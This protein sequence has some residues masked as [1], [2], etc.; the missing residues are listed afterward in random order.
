MAFC[1]QG[2]VI[3]N[4]TELHR[5][6]QNFVNAQRLLPP[7]EYRRPYQLYIGAIDKMVEEGAMLEK[8][9]LPFVPVDQ[10]GTQGAQA[11]VSAE[12]LTAA[13]SGQSTATYLMEEAIRLLPEPTPAPTIAPIAGRVLQVRP[14]LIP[15]LYEIVMHV[16][17]ESWVDAAE[18]RVG[19]FSASPYRIITIRHTCAS[20]FFDHIAVITTD[21]R[22]FESPKYTI[23]RGDA[24]P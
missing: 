20:D 5:I 15:D 17:I 16:N 1:L 11:P 14:S 7:P 2:D 3:D 22:Y 23:E 4:C 19:G 8:Q 6:Y 24:C 10:G 18:I 13:R 9:C 21:G 12:S